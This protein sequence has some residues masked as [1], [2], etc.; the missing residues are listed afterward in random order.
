MRTQVKSIILTLLWI[1]YYQTGNSQ[2]IFTDQKPFENYSTLTKLYKDALF[3][4]D[5][6]LKL[7]F[8]VHT[9]EILETSDSKYL[10]IDG[11]LSLYQWIDNKWVNKSKSIYHGYNFRS[12]KFTFEGIVHC[13]G[14]YGFWREHGDLIF[15][16]PSRGEWESKVLAY[17]SDVGNNVSFITDSILN[18]INPISRNQHVDQNEKR[19][20]LYQINLRT[21]QINVKPLDQ[22]LKALKFATRI[23]T[24]NLYMPSH[25]PLQLIHKKNLTYKMSDL[26]YLKELYK[27]NH[28]DLY[29]IKGDTLLILNRNLDLPF[30]AY[31]LLDIFNELPTEARSI[32]LNSRSSLPF[33]AA[34]SVF[35]ILG[36][37]IF[38]RKRNAIKRFEFTHPIISK[39]L[40]H[41]G[42]K[43]SQEELDKIFEIET[44][45]SPDTLKSRRS[46]LFK[47]IN[48]QYSSKTGKEL[49]IRIPDP[50]D[51]RKYLYHIT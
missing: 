48:S 51:K 28:H 46:N 17:I 4:Q 26:T 3:L 29:I 47:E 1:C 8:P 32:F 5:S 15:F 2:I 42:G 13:Y 50:L 30:V 33:V 34:I 43:L 10:L 27:Y 19:E 44:I 18:V 31:N 37:W 20:G 39:L 22:K 41:S 25:N 24:E 14:G 49:I 12:K 23:E 21:H 7:D 9:L 36:A 38:M 35:M 6:F 11:R 45:H 16:D 40:Q